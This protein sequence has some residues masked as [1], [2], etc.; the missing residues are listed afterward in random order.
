METI[1]EIKNE[2][3]SSS[4]TVYR[5]QEMRAIIIASSF[6]PMS[7]AFGMTPEQARKMAVALN[8]AADMADKN[9]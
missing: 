1:A 2:S 5:H 6:G 8:E 3:D 4:L 9:G 7:F